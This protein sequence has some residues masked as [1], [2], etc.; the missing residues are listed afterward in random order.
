[1]VAVES[2]VKMAAHAVKQT[3]L[4]LRQVTAVRVAMVAVAAM[5]PLVLQAVVVAMAP[6]VDTACQVW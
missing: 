2:T 3:L 6:L 5:V 1:M 4:I